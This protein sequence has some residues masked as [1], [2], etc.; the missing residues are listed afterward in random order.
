MRETFRSGQKLQF[1]HLDFETH[2]PK[3]CP[4][5]GQWVFKPCK[6]FSLSPIKNLKS[7]KM[8]KTDAKLSLAIGS[9]WKGLASK[10]LQLCKCQNKFKSFQILSKLHKGLCISEPLFINYLNWPTSTWNCNLELS[11]CFLMAWLSCSS[12]PS[13]SQDL[14]FSGFIQQPSK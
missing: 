6:T 13:P 9:D 12:L 1:R 2:P 10:T 11:L 7:A 5:S 14:H 8:S 3:S 4:C